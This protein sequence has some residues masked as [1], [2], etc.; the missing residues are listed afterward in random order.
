MAIVGTAECPF[1]HQ[2]VT[3]T[4]RCPA[5]RAP[6][7]RATAVR[8]PLA[9][10]SIP[11][12]AQAF[13]EAATSP[14]PACRCGDRVGSVLQA[15]SLS[16]QFPHTAERLQ[17][18]ADID[19]G[20]VRG[21]RFA[22]AT[23]DGTAQQLGTHLDEEKMLEA[24]GRPLSVRA[25][26][27]FFLQRTVRT[28]E[29]QIMT[30][31]GFAMV[32]APPGPRMAVVLQSNAELARMVVG[33]DAL[34][35]PLQEVDQLAARPAGTYHEW[36]S[37][38]IARAVEQKEIGAAVIV[39]P[40]AVMHRF[41]AA[42]EERG[43]RWHR[44]GLG[45]IRVEGHGLFF[46][47]PDPEW[48]LGDIRMRGLSIEEAAA[49]RAALVDAELRGMDA[50]RQRLGEAFS[51]WGLHPESPGP[52]TGGRNA[53]YLRVRH[54]KGNSFSV[55]LATIWRRAQDPAVF[56]AHVDQLRGILA[57]TPERLDRCACGR[58]AYITKKWKPLS[59]VRRAEA[60]G[61]PLLRQPALG[62]AAVFARDCAFHSM[63]VADT[64]ASG[65]PAMRELERRFQRDVA[66]HAF[67]LDFVFETDNQGIAAVGVW[68]RNVA[69]VALHP[70]LVAGA[71]A[72]AAL[73]WRGPIR[74]RAATTNVLALSPGTS[75]RPLQAA[76]ERAARA[77]AAGGDPGDGLAADGQVELADPMGQFERL[78][79]AA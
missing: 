66:R 21:V 31:P 26:W 10:L 38:Q 68:G 49:I 53:C 77:A 2:E 50:H 3:L 46:V 51:G 8:I 76:A 13:L 44:A 18:D 61:G 78:R 36:L 48:L 40:G 39:R 70:A 28:H 32:T 42:L 69:S 73:P 33:E 27:D 67:S 60:A 75:D 16:F 47:V 59:W 5:C 37:P 45:R 6:A 57:Q 41:G 15:A 24:F 56:A 30:F 22:R 4:Y 58:P 62:H 63:Y 9:Q 23:A 1:M 14:G 25:A 72:A 64:Q 29:G 71:L 11:A 65:G 52:E 74:F 79:P 20:A 54:P 17:L 34:V 43:L 35:V 19:Q 12:L 7:L 55:N